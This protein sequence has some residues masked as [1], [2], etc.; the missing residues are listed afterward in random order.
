M[1]ALVLST[2]LFV[3][4]WVS[5]SR[6]LS[7]VY[8]FLFSSRLSREAMAVL[9]GRQQHIKSESIY[10]LIRCI[11]RIEKGLIMKPRKKTFGADYIVDAVSLYLYYESREELSESQTQWASDVLREY[12]SVV[13]TSLMGE[14]LAEQLELKLRKP[15]NRKPFIRSSQPPCS[16]DLSNLHKLYLKRRSVRWFKDQEVPLGVLEKTIEIASLAP[17]ACNRQPFS[18]YL[19]DDDVLKHKLLDLAPGVGGFK[20]GIPTVLALVGDLSA[21]FHE[22]DRHVIYIDASL[23]AMQFMLALETQGYS[24]CPINWPDIEDNERQAASIL[25]LSTCER[26]VMLIAVGVADPEGM[27]PY[28]EK[29]SSSYLLKKIK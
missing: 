28:S 15:L 9:N 12:T 10:R 16:I 2:Y 22:R 1:K 11:H 4:G 18:L 24:S 19:P 21:Y 27:I 3:V 5:R 29:K 26:I 23:F 7:S 25:G 14:S 8:Y 20:S 6:F 13:G 17:S